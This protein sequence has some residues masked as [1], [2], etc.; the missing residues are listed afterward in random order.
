ME[1]VGYLL[2]VFAG[3]AAG[4]PDAGATIRGSV[5]EA[6]QAPRRPGRSPYP[7]NRRTLAA[8]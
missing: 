2:A 6:R 7:R 5:R 3:I 1:R 8:G 4:I